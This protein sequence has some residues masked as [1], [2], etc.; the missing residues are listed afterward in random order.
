MQDWIPVIVALIA[1]IAA[2][3]GYLIN[4]RLNRLNDKMK[5]YAEALAAIEHY[6]QLPYA[7]YRLH[8]ST[9]ETRAQLAKMIGE[10]QENLAFHRRWLDLDSPSVGSAYNKLVDK[11]RETNSTY[12]RQAFDAPPPSADSDLESFGGKF[13][14]HSDAERTECMLAMRRELRLF[15]WPMR[16]RP[17]KSSSWHL[18]GYGQ[19]K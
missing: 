18:L 5:A 12:R 8:D 16:V 10:T 14:T 7:I 11:I 15:R 13:H 4:G 6:K 2:L 3:A 17:T 9:A 19:K 1:A